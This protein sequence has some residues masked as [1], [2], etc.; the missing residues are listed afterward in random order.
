[1]TYLG[2]LLR[3]R[4]RVKFT[5]EALKLKENDTPFGERLR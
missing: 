4:V 5:L 3:L 2:G 1:M